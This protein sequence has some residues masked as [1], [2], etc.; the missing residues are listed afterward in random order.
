MRVIFVAILLSNF[1]FS[2]GGVIIFNDGTTIEGDVTN[3]NE[4][5]IFITPMGLTFPEEI[6]ME[7]V[8]S[9]K[10]YDGKLLVANNKALILYANGQYFEPGLVQDNNYEDY[11]DYEVEYVLVPNWSVNIYTGYPLIRS[12]SLSETYY[13]K[14]NPVIGLSLGSP[15]GLFFGDF[16]MNG[17]FELAHYKF[18]KQDQEANVQF[19]GFA[20][21]IGVS[22]GF[23]I[24]ETSVSLTACT[25]IYHA[26]TG[27]IGGGSI[28]LPLGSILINSFQ[29]SDFIEDYEEIIESF[30]IRLTSRANIVQ[31]REGGSTYWMDAGVSFGYEF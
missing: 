8:D 24:G 19:D 22:P 14:I 17:I 15:Y 10:L 18:T 16:F 3:V 6:R 27:L 12:E 2:V 7:N 20:Y 26:G 11:E 21:Q 23:F 5:S 28:D 31:K 30:E 13:D 4:S 1:L 29:D 9:L 25:G